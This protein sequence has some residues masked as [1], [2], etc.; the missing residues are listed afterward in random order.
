ML[1]NEVVRRL[2]V[3]NGV[4]WWLK[5]AFIPGSDASSA[6]R[7]E[8][9]MVIRA[10]LHKSPQDMQEFIH[11]HTNGLHSGEW[12]FRPPLQMRIELG[13]MDRP[14]GGADR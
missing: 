14:G 4:P 3:L 7:G 12:I 11:E 10:V 9:R 6:K 1:Y 5:R 8:G 13:K 2:K